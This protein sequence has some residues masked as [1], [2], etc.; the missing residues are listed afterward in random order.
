MPQNVPITTQ[1]KCPK[2]ISASFIAVEIWEDA[3]IYFTVKD[4]ILDRH[5]G[6]LEPGNPHKVQGRCDCGHIWTFKKAHQ[7][8]DI[9]NGTL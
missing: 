5:N 4:S 6:M 1:N 9:T 8:D 2:C 3:A 7:I